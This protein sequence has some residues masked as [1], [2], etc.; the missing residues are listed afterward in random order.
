[1]NDPLRYGAF[2]NGLVG[3]LIGAATLAT[4]LPARADNLLGLYVGAGVGQS[5]VRDD[6]STFSNL[7]GFVKNH[8][9]WK[10]LIGIRPI[11]LVGA[12]I[13][14]ADFG[15]PGE[16]VASV[17]GLASHTDVSQ[18]AGSLFGLVY[19]PLPVPI[20]DVYGKA[21]FSELRTTVNA[22]FT[23]VGIG[24]LCVRNPGPYHQESTDTRFAYGAGVQAKF[25]GLAVRAEYEQISAPSGSPNLYSL[26]ATWTF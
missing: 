24:V 16:S 20:L 2:R 15:H 4:S 18:K 11:S 22:S 23:C 6:L 21:G 25:L 7:G 10:A 9:G 17:Q 13:E 8:T 14:Y 3:I 5:H 19:L 12:E 26:I 1:M